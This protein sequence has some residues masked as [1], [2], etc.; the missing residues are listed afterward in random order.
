MFLA[1][2]TVTAAFR[3]TR[4]IV[5]VN[6][7][8]VS[9]STLCTVILMW[10]EREMT[11][12]ESWFGCIYSSKYYSVFIPGNDWQRIFMDPTLGRISTF[13]LSGQTDC[14]FPINVFDSNCQAFIK[15]VWFKRPYVLPGDQ[16]KATMMDPHL[17]E[18]NF[19]FFFN[20]IPNTEPLGISCF[21]TRKVCWERL[22]NRRL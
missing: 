13:F 8:I 22:H 2:R 3:N 9:W 14:R 1:M 4:S 17:A 5:V 15:K 16:A 20:E 7:W 11:S 12:F 6:R 21:K 18:L 19:N 10:K